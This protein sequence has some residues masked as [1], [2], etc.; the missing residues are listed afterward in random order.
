MARLV[1][2]HGFTQVGASWQPILPALAGHEVITIDAPGHGRNA[3]V[4]ADLAETG[5]LLAEHGP[6]I[7]IG[8]SMGGRMCLHVPRSA[9]TGLVLVSATA[10][11]DDPD[12]R[13]VRRR[14]D[15]VL[16]DRIEAIGTEA[17]LEEWLALPL[18][19]GLRARGPRSSDAAG[20]A[21]SLRLAGTGTQEPMWDRLPALDVPVL[22]VAGGDDEKF[23]AIA[24]RMHDALPHSELHVIDGAGHTVH[25][26]QPEAFTTTLLGWL[27]VMR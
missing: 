16:A 21:T 17:F 9:M 10:G 15:E 18:F 12:E 6:A 8:Y 3:N 26:E 2:V 4:R 25:L 14:S 7:Y 27:D 1:L 19:A 22:L 24:E 11:I 13:A 5:E 20:L 23:V